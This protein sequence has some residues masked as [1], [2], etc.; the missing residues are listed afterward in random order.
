MKPGTPS[1]EIKPAYWCNICDCPQPSELRIS[2]LAKFVVSLNG[3]F[4]IFLTSSILP[5]DY[6]LGEHMLSKPHKWAREVLKQ[7]LSKMVKVSTNLGAPYGKGQ[8]IQLFTDVMIYGS[9]QRSVTNQPRVGDSRWWPLKRMVLATPTPRPP[10][11]IIFFLQA[12]GMQICLV[13]LWALKCHSM[14]SRGP[15]NLARAF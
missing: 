6:N 3:R 13:S 12:C 9:C 7:Q 5:G 4:G 10:S 1:F 15:E 14:A 11:H 2:E 8:S